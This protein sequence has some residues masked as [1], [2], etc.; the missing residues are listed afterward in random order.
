MH[1]SQDSMDHAAREALII[2]HGPDVWRTAID[3]NVDS[4]PFV[5]AYN[6]YPQKDLMWERKIALVSTKIVNEKSRMAPVLETAHQN[7][8]SRCHQ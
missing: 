4:P 2:S 5:V 6:T 7:T 8:A 3:K 1:G